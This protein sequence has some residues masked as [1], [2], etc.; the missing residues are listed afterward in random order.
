MPGSWLWLA[1]A[2]CDS[3]T[4]PPQT[5]A[6]ELG[7]ATTVGYDP[8]AMLCVQLEMDPDDFVELGHQFRFGTDAEDQ[9]PGVLGHAFSSC[10]DPFPDP[11][12][13][14]RADVAIDGLSVSD[15]GVRKKGFIGSVLQ[16]SETRPSLKLDA[17]E[18]V[19]DQLFGD[20]ERVTLNNNLSD[21]TRL[22]QCLSYA[23]FTDA[24]YPAPR[25]NLANVMVNG[26]S[27]GAYTHV[28]PI[29]K[30]FLRQHFD[31][32]HGSLYE[33]TLA[34]FSD[35]HLADGLGRWEAKT[36]DSN[37]TAELLQTIADALDV[38]DDGLEPALDAVLDLDRFLE[39]WALETLL[40][41]DDG[42]SSF[43]NNT[44]VYFDPDQGDRAVFIPWGTDGAMSEEGTGGYVSS[45]LTRRL[46]RHPEL[47]LRYLEALETLLN[48]VWDE[49]TLH[50]RVAGLAPQ[51]AT[52]E[53]T[54]AQHD[55]A[56]GRLTGWIDGRR[57]AI[58]AL[59]AA[60][61][62]QGDPEPGDCNGALNLD[63]LLDVS[64]VVAFSAHGC[65]AAPHRAHAVWWLAMAGLA[66]RRRQAHAP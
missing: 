65:T 64:E 46:S 29:K 1:L 37:P 22:H 19:D 50:D 10:T 16:G 28:E 53:Q 60:G 5:S 66:V 9:F 8:D 11:Y 20:V 36:S 26:V 42:Y 31:N 55:D 41:H 45:A 35:A 44:Y 48:E 33:T 23:V 34:D 30:D 24:D 21:P 12:T 32:D 38:D 39:F 15:A 3:E 61:G 51:V 17:D 43:T 13:W 63:E 40:A 52:A 49:P 54:T 7:S 27:L 57:A 56:V 47:S 14:F 6:C 2:A 4:A 25:C 59:I 18:F 58:E 62:V